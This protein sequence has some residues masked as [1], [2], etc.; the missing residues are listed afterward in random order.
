MLT[1]FNTVPHVVVTPNHTIISLLLRN[2]N[3]VTMM[4]YN[5]NIKYMVTVGL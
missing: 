1:P 4:N 2:C 5:A 3:F